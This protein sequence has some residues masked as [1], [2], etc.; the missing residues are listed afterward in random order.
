MKVCN[1]FEIQFLTHTINQHT[2]IQ[3]LRSKRVTL[4]DGVDSVKEPYQ[5]L[6]VCVDKPLSYQH[7]SSPHNCQNGKFTVYQ[8]PPVSLL[9]MH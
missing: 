4:T 9:M 6:C 5:P 2:I 8:S 3:L 1:I 7:L